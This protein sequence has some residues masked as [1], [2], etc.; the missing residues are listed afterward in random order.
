MSNKSQLWS[1]PWIV[2]LILLGGIYVL[3]LVFPNARHSRSDKSSE[4]VPLSSPSGDPVAVLDA[5][6]VGCWEGT[7]EAL[8]SLDMKCRRLGVDEGEAYHL[9]VRWE[10]SDFSIPEHRISV[11]SS[12]LDLSENH[13]SHFT[14]TAQIFEV[15]TPVSEGDRIDESNLSLIN[16]AMTRT[17]DRWITTTTTTSTPI[18]RLIEDWIN[19]DRDNNGILIAVDPNQSSSIDDYNAILQF[20]HNNTAL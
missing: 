10:L 14:G 1:N 16:V 11:T 5:D 12:R 2:A 13:H 3:A 4:A 15:L 8:G 7:I 18:D 20:V 17:D 19:G 6:T 9:Y